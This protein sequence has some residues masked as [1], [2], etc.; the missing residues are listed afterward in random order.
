MNQINGTLFKEPGAPKNT[1]PLILFFEETAVKDERASRNGPPVFFPVHQVRVV[2]AGSKGNEGPIYEMA[3]KVG[4]NWKMN[5]ELR[6]QKFLRPYEDWKAGRVSADEGMPLEQWALMDVALVATFKASHVYTVQQLATLPDSALDNAIRRGGR[7]WRAKAQAWLEEAKT[8]AG[9]VEAR[10]TIARQQEQIDALQAQL[11][12]VLKQQNKQ[13]TG[14]DKPK[15]GRQTR[16]EVETGDDVA[17]I[18]E[19]DRRL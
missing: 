3:R 17:V 16:E 4:D 19:A 11:S 7:E 10:A 1:P 15:R 2:V 13:T 14:Y 18:E 6:P 9:D 12:E 8:A 5:N